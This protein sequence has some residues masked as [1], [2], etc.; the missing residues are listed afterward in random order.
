MAIIKTVRSITRHDINTVKTGVNLLDWCVEHHPNCFNFNKVKTVVLCNGLIIAD[1][2]ELSSEELQKALDFDVNGADYIEIRQAPRGLIAGSYLL[3]ALAVGAAVV[4]LPTV[5]NWLIDI[6]EL[7]NN[8]GASSSSPNANLK[9][10]S[11][12]FRLRQGIPNKS[13]ETF[14]VPDFIQPSYFEYVNNL[15]VVK[16]L[17]CVGEGSHSISNIKDGEALISS[18]TGSSATVYDLVAGDVVPADVQKTVVGSNN[19][20]GQE[21]NAPDAAIYKQTLDIEFI[22]NNQLKFAD[23]ETVIED[24]EWVIGSLFRISTGLS[25]GDYEIANIT[26][27]GGFYTIETVETTIVTE[28]SAATDLV[29]L[30]DDGDPIDGWTDYIVI[31]EAVGT[32]DV[33]FQITMPQGIESK[34]GKRIEIDI[35]MEVVASLTGSYSTSY[36]MSASFAGADRTEKAKTFKLSD[37]T[38]ALSDLINADKVEIRARRSTNKFDGAAAQS[39]KLE[40]VQWV[41]DQDANDFDGLTLLYLERKATRAALGS[42]DNKINCIAQRKL[43]LFDPNTG[44][45]G[46]TYEVTRQAADYIFY[47]LYELG[48]LPLSAIDTD[49]LFDIKDNLPTENLGYFDY[50][51]D[52]KEISLE[53]RIETAANAM[54]C[55]AF[56][57]GRIWSFVRDEEK[58]LR[59][60]LI[61]PR[62]MKGYGEESF[63]F[64]KPNDKDSVVIRY[65]DPDENNNKF[66]E[67]RINQTTG[68]IEDGRG[69]NPINI[70]MDFCR[71]EAQAINRAELE[72]RKIAYIMRSAT[73]EVTVDGLYVN[74]GDRIGWANPID[75]D[76]QHGEI[77]SFSA[78]DYDT[79]ERFIDNGV[80]TYYCYT[81]DEDGLPTSAPFVVAARVDTE[82]GF[83]AATGQA[84]DAVGYTQLGSRYIIATLDNLNLSDWTV[85]SRSGRNSDGSVT[86]ELSE[87]NAAVY[88]ED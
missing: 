5:I 3:T 58:P 69:D 79:T 6:P 15:K 37:F 33:W 78:G 84:Y 80:D 54:R 24:F 20:D 44:T 27:S 46:A 52:D 34:D 21:L 19:I 88:E 48:G 49:A 53:Q 63:S 72:I 23:T 41:V 16:E 51:F 36:L 43:K 74:L 1:V 59:T 4:A 29:R 83:T 68:A 14:C 32:D 67:R 25:A 38:G 60:A 30:N 13:G 11:N 50:S 22:A 47:V 2:D 28:A 77:L 71:N 64:N 55:T 62:I 81:T 9:A 75:N 57:S 17:F 35:E 86:I 87:Y 76:T 65:V 42:R 40:E 82:F 39:V 66:I 56:K 8:Q 26:D 73:L 61:S 31:R 7:P 45:V 18:I 12:Q 85:I 10:A 70:E